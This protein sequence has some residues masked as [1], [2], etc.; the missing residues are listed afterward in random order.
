MQ[1]RSEHLSVLEASSSIA[2]TPLFQDYPVDVDR[3][4][5]NEGFQPTKTPL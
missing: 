4:G 1:F 3:P 2:L 5:D